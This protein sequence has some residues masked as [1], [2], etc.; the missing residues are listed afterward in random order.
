MTTAD[1]A[2][3][4]T[5]DLRSAWPNEAQNFTPWLFANLDR[6]ADAIGIPLESDGAEV[7]VESFSAD[8]LARNP[9]DDSRVLIENQLECSDH[10][11]LGQLMTYLAG[12]EAK[13]IVWVAADFREA[14]LS[15]LEWLNESTDTEFAFFAVRVRVVRIGDSPLA[16]VFDV[17]ARPNN[18]ERRLHAAAS[19]STELSEHGKR[20][21]TF[22][23]RF[24]ER[25]PD[26]RERIGEPCGA[27]S[28]WYRLESIDLVLSLFISKSKVGLFV[29][30]RMGVSAEEVAERLEPHLTD[31]MK[32]TGP[33]SRVNVNGCLISQF[34]GN[35]YEPELQDE[36]IDWLYA[37][38]DRYKTALE[39]VLGEGA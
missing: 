19:R 16:P 2:R 37:A 31:L 24:L 38:A 18:W 9:Q 5:A 25:H 20:N 35:P 6:L 22:W 26:A 1:L 33:D 3:L 12:L 7:P 29:R 11:H 28:R 4:E 10:T 30:G 23:S 17:V 8:I 36:L 34:D 14:H 27:Y 32:R 21:L 39:E 13:T 15:A